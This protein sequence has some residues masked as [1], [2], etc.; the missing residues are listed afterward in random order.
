MAD[1]V[2]SEREYVPEPSV[3]RRFSMHAVVR[4]SDALPSSYWR[5]DGVARALQDAATEDWADCGIESDAWWLARRTSFRAVGPWPVIYDQL[6]LTTFCSG[7]G[8][9]WAERRTNIYLDD[10]LVI[11]ASSLWVPVD[12]RGFP[13]RIPATFHGIFGE[14]MN[15]RKISGR[16]PVSAPPEGTPRRPW[17]LRRA[18]LDVIGHVNNAAVWQAVAEI[19]DAPV[20]EV[21]VIHHGPVEEGHRVELATSE[22]A[23]WL[24][25]D[26][27]VR[28]AVRVVGDPARDRGR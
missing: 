5:L 6:K 3:G 17:P 11:E 9:A 13:V 24:L 15:G 21:D 18:D 14:S 27:E 28:V 26:G 2:V 20:T 16:V 4:L 1:V 12:P 7:A 23:M 25:V 10:R 22:A 8:A 19:F